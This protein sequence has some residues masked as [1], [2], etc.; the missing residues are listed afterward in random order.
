MNQIKAY[1]PYAFHPR[2]RS[3]VCGNSVHP[4]FTRGL[5]GSKKLLVE[6]ITSTTTIEKQGIWEL[7]ALSFLTKITIL[8]WLSNYFGLILAGFVR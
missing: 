6:S 2:N 1:E 3:R 5:K 8:N 7:Q 4:S